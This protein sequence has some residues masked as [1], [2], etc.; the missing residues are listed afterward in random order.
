MFSPLFDD[1]V[2]QEREHHSER[3]Q[4]DG[5]LE[6]ERLNDEYL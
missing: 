5:I 4:H 3:D 6:E 2:N 1:G